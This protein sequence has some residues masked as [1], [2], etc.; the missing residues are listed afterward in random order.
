MCLQKHKL[1]PGSRAEQEEQ[2]NYSGPVW[3][4]GWSLGTSGAAFAPWFQPLLCS[5]TQTHTG[6]G[7]ERWGEGREQ[8]T[9]THQGWGCWSRNKCCQLSRHAVTHR[10]RLK[11]WGTSNC[12]HS[13]S[14]QPM[15][16]AQGQSSK[17]AFANVTHWE[18]EWQLQFWFEN[19]GIQS[20]VL[21]LEILKPEN[22]F[23]IYLYIKCLL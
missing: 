10:Q 19:Q 17:E 8:Q 1:T 11:D 3:A 12:H 23:Y 9:A 5:H 18:R 2:P 14:C 20:L 13:R 7:L 15:D 4:P 21:T 16:T 22:K 6:T